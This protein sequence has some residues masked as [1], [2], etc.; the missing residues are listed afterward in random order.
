MYPYLGVVQE[1]IE[2]GCCAEYFL[3]SRSIC[4]AGSVIQKPLFAFQGADVG[5][6]LRDLNTAFVLVLFITEGKIA[7]VNEL[8]F[9][10]DPEFCDITLPRTEIV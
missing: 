2:R 6:I 5:C 8:P 4:I 3:L 9:C 10:L 1:D 7:D